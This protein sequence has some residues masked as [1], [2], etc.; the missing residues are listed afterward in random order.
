[1]RPNLKS[2]WKGVGESRRVQSYKA[3]TEVCHLDNIRILVITMVIRILAMVM[4]RMIGVVT[5]MMKAGLSLLKITVIKKT[6]LNL[7][8]FPKQKSQTNVT[9]VIMHVITNH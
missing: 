9:N 1:M 7:Q 3:L 5:L 2:F 6:I 8:S 4:V